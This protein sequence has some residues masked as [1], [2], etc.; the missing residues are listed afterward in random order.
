M[1]DRCTIRIRCRRSDAHLF[2][3]QF[4]F[5]ID[6]SHYPDRVIPDDDECSPV[7]ELYDEEGYCEQENY[8][9]VPYFGNHGQ[10]WEYGPGEFC[11]EGKG[12][13]WYRET[14]RDGSHGLGVDQHGDPLPKD[15]ASLKGFLA[16]MDRVHDVLDATPMPEPT[17]PRFAAEHI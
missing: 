15:V 2:I 17:L 10:G 5:H 16:A 11:C 12:E 9:D 3:D 8:P 13:D 4:N 1:G 6:E 7:V 14:F